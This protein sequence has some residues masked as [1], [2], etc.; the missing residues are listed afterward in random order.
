MC[1]L[2]EIFIYAD[3]ESVAQ[4]AK[5]EV[6]IEAVVR[7]T[8]VRLMVVGDDL[9]D[10]TDQL[11]QQVT[12][13]VY[14]LDQICRDYHLTVDDVRA[15]VNHESVTWGTNG[16]AINSQYEDL[17]YDDYDWVTERPADTN[18]QLD[19][20]ELSADAAQVEPEPVEVPANLLDHAI[21]ASPLQLLAAAQPFLAIDAQ[22]NDLYLALRLPN[23]D[24][25][26][27]E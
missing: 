8:G 6:F 4:T 12:D 18:V 3:I 15:L 1:D 20:D 13:Q 11:Y 17:D 5:N 9:D 23:P 24:E 21:L 26:G 10:A 27:S 22:N 7:K 19:S 16:H 25:L 2:S 14:L